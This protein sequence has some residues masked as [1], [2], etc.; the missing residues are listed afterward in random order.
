MDETPMI[1]TSDTALTI[2]VDPSL[3]CVNR[4]I[5]SV[6]SEP[7]RN[8]VV[9]KFSKDSRKATAAPPIIAGLKK[10]RVINLSLIHI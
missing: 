2:G 4:V 7:T 5:G 9:L 10:G 6:A 1:S 8:R 3:I